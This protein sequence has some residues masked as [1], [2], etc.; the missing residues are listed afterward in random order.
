MVYP[1][2]H[3]QYPQIAPQP[4]SRNGL[5][6]GLGIGGL[7][8]TLLI[9]GGV[10]AVVVAL[11]RKPAS[12]PPVAEPRISLSPTAS[13]QPS[14][15]PGPARLV[16]PDQIGTRAKLTDAE[17]TKLVADTEAKMKASGSAGTSYIV[18][19]Y[20]TADPKIDKVRIHGSNSVSGSMSRKVFDDQFIAI[21]K[22]FNGANTTGIVVVSPGAKLGFVS[23]GQVV[24]KDGMPLAVCAWAGQ[25]TGTFVMVFWYNRAPSDAIKKEILVIRD[26]VEKTD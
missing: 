16:T 4:K 25:G 20:G 7:V 1:P 3:D 6:I 26:L 18:A 12:P 19:Y 24:A 22:Q 9:C 10:I 14:K 5:W 8:L 17:H 15:K 11:N 2:P 23:C 21:G 13:A